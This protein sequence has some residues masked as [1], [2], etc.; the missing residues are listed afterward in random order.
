MKTTCHALGSFMKQNGCLMLL[1]PI[2]FLQSLLTLPTLDRN[3]EVPLPSFMCCLVDDDVI[4][5]SNGCVGF[6]NF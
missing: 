6:H 4:V 5:A 2:L 1:L 3:V